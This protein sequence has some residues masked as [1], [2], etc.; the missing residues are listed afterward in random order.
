MVVA[1]G[2]RHGVREAG[3]REQ[4]LAFQGMPGVGL[5]AAKRADLV[6]ER[7]RPQALVVRRHSGPLADG[8]G[9]GR[10]Q[11]GAARPAQAAVDGVSG[12]DDQLRPDLLQHLEQRLL[13]LGQPLDQRRIGQVA[14]AAF[15]LGQV[16]GLVGGHQQLVGGEGVLGQAGQPDA[17]RQRVRR[18][19]AD[20]RGMDAGEQ[21]LGEG[22]GAGQAGVGEDHRQLVTPVA[23]DQVVGAG[24]RPHQPPRTPDDLVAVLVAHGVVDLF[25][26]VEI[27]DH[28]RHRARN[29]APQGHLLDQPAPKLSVVQQSGQPIG[30]RLLCAALVT[31]RVGQRH[32]RAAGQGVDREEV[33]VAERVAAGAQ[34][35][36]CG[37]AVARGQRH[38][39][40]GFARSE[41]RLAAA[42]HRARHLGIEL[43]T[44]GD[45]DALIGDQHQPAPLR[46]GHAQR[47]LEDHG[48]DVLYV[49]AGVHG[50][51]HLAHGVRLGGARDRDP[52]LALQLAG[53]DRDHQRHRHEEENLAQ[54]R[55]Q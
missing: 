13:V 17:Q 51:A 20:A 37:H 16:E 21:A 38:Q 27:D 24:G 5:I 7:R 2:L 9:H 40:L 12:G 35:E 42:G 43:L 8:L 22:G 28:H 3:Q 47:A 36:D 18:S 53:H 55:Q 29:R 41:L 4:P 39:Q 14:I 52:P 44:G 25:E 54:R 34:P 33:L 48:E 45:L 11:A 10:H 32:G 49:K 31:E 6:Q 50:H 19:G 23:G 30:D 1:D 26:V 15:A 46:A